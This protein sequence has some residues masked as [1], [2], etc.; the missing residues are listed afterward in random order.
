MLSRSP[1]LEEWAWAVGAKLIANPNPEL[2]G[3]FH[4][5]NSAGQV[6]T[7]QVGIDG[8]VFA[9]RRTTASRWLKTRSAPAQ[10]RCGRVTT[11]LLNARRGPEQC[12]S[13]YNRMA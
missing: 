6:R 9:K 2:L 3:A 10:G 4:L 12:H 1:V 13:M 11:V 8:F 7:Q 5:P